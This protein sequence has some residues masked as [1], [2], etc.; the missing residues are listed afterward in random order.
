[1]NLKGREGVLK[2][3]KVSEGSKGYKRVLTGLRGTVSVQRIQKGPE[4]C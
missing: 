4:G 1:M 3:L 2:G